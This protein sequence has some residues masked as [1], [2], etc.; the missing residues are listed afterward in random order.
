MSLPKKTDCVKCKGHEGRLIEGFYT[1]YL[2]FTC[3]FKW[4][5]TVI[6]IE[7]GPSIKGL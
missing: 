7:K 5:P 3:G 1:Y 4:A 6:N 2:C